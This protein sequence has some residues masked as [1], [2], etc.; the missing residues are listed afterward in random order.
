MS[1]ERKDAGMTKEKKPQCSASVARSRGR[2]TDFG[3]CENS[4]AVQV[5]K[6]HLCNMHFKKAQ[7][8]G[9]AMVCTGEIG[10]TYPNYPITERITVE[11]DHEA[12]RSKRRAEFD[13]EQVNRRREW[14]LRTQRFMDLYAAARERLIEHGIDVADLDE[15]KEQPLM[16]SNEKVPE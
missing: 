4:G 2:W 1:D 5:G 10:K 14:S 11:P 9:R 8:D 15:T 16:Y 3:Q 13:K 7:I 6:Y 12:I